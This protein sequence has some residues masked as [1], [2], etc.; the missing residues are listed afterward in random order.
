MKVGADSM[1]NEIR[2]YLETTSVSY[3]AASM[4]QKMIRRHVG[5]IPIFVESGLLV[6]PD[7]VANNTQLCSRLASSNGLVTATPGSL[8]QALAH[9][10]NLTNQKGFRGVSMVTT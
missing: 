7:C 9:L 6:L 10:I 2:T 3:F 8:H 5:I 4:G 1:T